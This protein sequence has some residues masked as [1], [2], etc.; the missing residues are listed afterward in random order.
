MVHEVDDKSPTQVVG[1][2]KTSENAFQTGEE[3]AV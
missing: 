1:G 3:A 2:P